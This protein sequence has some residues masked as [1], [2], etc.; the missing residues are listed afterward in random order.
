MKFTNIDNTIH[1]SP[2]IQSDSV[3]HHNSANDKSIPK[4]INKSG[5]SMTKNKII[6]SL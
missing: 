6:K 2:I 4:K 5:V 1:E 3:H